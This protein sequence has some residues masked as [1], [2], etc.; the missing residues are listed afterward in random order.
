MAKRIKNS[1]IFLV[2]TMGLIPF[3]RAQYVQVLSVKPE[4]STSVNQVG[5]GFHSDIRPY[6]MYEIKAKQDDSVF[7]FEKDSNRKK[8][9]FFNEENLWQWQSKK[10]WVVVKPLVNLSWGFE[11]DEK[12]FCNENNLGFSASYSYKNKLAAGFTF[13]GS[14]SVFPKDINEKINESHIIPGG[15]GRAFRSDL[16][17]YYALNY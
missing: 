14:Q 3:S 7:T 10:S 11:S 2:A 16:G 5:S 9:A 15:Y 8:S 4:I 13:F 6:Y 17:G 1:I 12:K